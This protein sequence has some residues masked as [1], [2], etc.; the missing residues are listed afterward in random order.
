ME[1]IAVETTAVVVLADGPSPG[2]AAH[3]RGHLFEAFVAQLL[4]TQGYGEPTTEHLNVTSEGVEI[5]VVA[6]HRAGSSA[7][8]RPTR[9]PFVLRSSR[10]SWESLRWLGQMTRLAMASSLGFH[11]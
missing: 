9:P 7:S 6:R 4:A 5:D 1:R 10:H 2:D 11:A 3:R 8:A